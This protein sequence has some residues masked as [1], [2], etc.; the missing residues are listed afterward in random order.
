MATMVERLLAVQEHDLRIRAM[1]REQRDIPARQEE[2]RGRLEQHR[3][4]LAE[5]QDALKAKQADVKALE[6]ETDAGRG[7]IDKLR[8]QQLD[9]KTNK[10][11]K[12]MDQEIAVIEAEIAQVED[13]E[14]VQM[15]EIE[16][17]RGKVE[18][19]RRELA[20]EE[21]AVNDV[22]A[23]LDQRAAGLEARL[24]KARAE[25]AV[26]AADADPEWLA[27]YDRIFERKEP[28]L[29][30]LEDGICGGCHMKLPPAVAHDARRGDRMVSCSYCQRL[31][32]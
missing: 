22:V 19:R 27:R 8:R 23:E 29:V 31:L 1:E 5:A 18:T 32:Y 14:L 21:A 12:A 9:L 17:L 4:A 2:E 11:F 20:A 24:G 16:R 6:L 28:A 25:R 15:E 26:A 30:A 10:E 3:A 7:K 13:R